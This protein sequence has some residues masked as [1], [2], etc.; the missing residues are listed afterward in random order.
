MTHL[1]LVQVVA[2]DSAH[3]VE[4]GAFLLLFLAGMALMAMVAALIFG[5]KRVP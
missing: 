5:T 4:P 2:A 1:L 3:G